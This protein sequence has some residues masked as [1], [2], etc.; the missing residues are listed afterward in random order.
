MSVC[1]HGRATV[2]PTLT[3][4]ICTSKKTGTLTIV[5]SQPHSRQ[6]CCHKPK[7]PEQPSLLSPSQ[8]HEQFPQEN[9]HHG[10]L[11]SVYQ[12]GGGGYMVIFYVVKSFVELMDWMYVRYG[13]I[14]PGDIM[15]NQYKMQSI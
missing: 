8:E 7:I 2:R 4:C 13:Q 10:R 1:R 9:R 11:Q 15:Q 5:P 6:H 3:R 14:I 12:E